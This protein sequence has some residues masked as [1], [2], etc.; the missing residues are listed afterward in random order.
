MIIILKVRMMTSLFYGKFNLY[1]K[2]YS[3][4]YNFLYK[5]T[6][7]NFRYI[8]W[9]KIQQKYSGAVGEGNRG[10]IWPFQ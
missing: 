6:Y 9:T 4:L 3:C 2:K 5:F 7:I 1:R 8:R 10:A